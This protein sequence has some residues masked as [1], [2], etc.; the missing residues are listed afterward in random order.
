MTGFDESRLKWSYNDRAE[1]T[2]T[3]GEPNSTSDALMICFCAK[4]I[5]SRLR[6]IECADVRLIRCLMEGGGGGKARDALR[7]PGRGSRA[8]SPRQH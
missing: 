8:V 1:D 3:G 7:L 5:S 2:K 4:M 6:S